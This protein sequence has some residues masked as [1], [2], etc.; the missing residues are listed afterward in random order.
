MSSFSGTYHAVPLRLLSGIGVPIAPRAELAVNGTSWASPPPPTI[1][2]RLVTVWL[3][4]AVALGL[5]VEA[6]GL[7]WT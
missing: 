4:G 5:L 7:Y 6:A 3:L 2:T 1:S